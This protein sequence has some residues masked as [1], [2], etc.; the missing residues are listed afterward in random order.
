LGHIAHPTA[1][2]PIAFRYPPAR[3]QARKKS[4]RVCDERSLYVM[5]SPSGTRR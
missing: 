5:L 4:Y 3:P 2:C 1:R